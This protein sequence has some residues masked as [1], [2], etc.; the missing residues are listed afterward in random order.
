MN[1]TSTFETFLANQ[2]SELDWKIFLVNLLCASILSLI[3]KKFYTKTGRSLTNRS[4]FSQNFLIL[5]LTTLVIITIVKSSLALSLGLVG[6]L[7]IVRFRAA[8]KEPEELLYLFLCIAIG[9]GFGANQGHIITIAI[10]FILFALFL[11]K[12]MRTSQDFSNLF[13][14]LNYQKES[15]DKFELFIQSIKDQ[16][17]HLELKNFS[18]DKQEV[19][20]TFLIVFED[21]K[22]FQELRDNLKAIDPAIQITYIEN[23]GF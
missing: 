19:E 18:E 23:K 9:L 12:K 14:T 10:C 3:L 11:Q 17:S 7:S 6:A 5:T 2:S 4:E 21:F 20:A 1:K 22:K 15:K 8:I 13:L 16:S